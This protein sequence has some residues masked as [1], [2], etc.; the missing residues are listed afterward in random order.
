M[1][2]FGLMSTYHADNE[3]C[4]FSGMRSG[5]EITSR[6]S[7]KSSWTSSPDDETA[8]RAR[9]RSPR[10]AVNR[11][12]R[13]ARAKRRGSAQCVC[14][15]AVSLRGAVRTCGCAVE[16]RKVR[17]FSPSLLSHPLTGQSTVLFN[18]VHNEARRSAVR[19]YAAGNAQP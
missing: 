13:F 3:Y 18:E 2:G 11:P 19:P 15:E 4:V 6:S 12:F 1:T 14:S 10:R 9:A 7:D 5:F 16:K 8:V 17:L